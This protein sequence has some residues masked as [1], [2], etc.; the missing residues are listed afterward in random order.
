MIRM[1]VESDLS[2]IMSIW[3]DNSTDNRTDYIGRDDVLSIIQSGELENECRRLLDHTYV[4]ENKDGIS[5]LVIIR[6]G[7]IERLMVQGDYQGLYVGD[8]LYNFAFSK[9]GNQPQEIKVLTD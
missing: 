3:M 6:D 1:A 7:A 4:A 2:Q 8:Y 9:V 5:G